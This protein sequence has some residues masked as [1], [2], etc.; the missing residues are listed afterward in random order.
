MKI[1]ICDDEQ[2]YLDNLKTHVQEY[3]ENRGIDIILD[4]YTDPSAVMNHDCVYDLAFLDIKMEGIDGIT[5]A[6]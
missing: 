3:M 5:L 1:L 4:T 2:L 6:R